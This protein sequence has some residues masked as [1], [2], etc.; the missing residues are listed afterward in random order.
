MSVRD[1]ELKN[2]CTFKRNHHS[3]S[4]VKSKE[5]R[6][7]ISVISSTLLETAASV[8]VAATVVG[9]TAT[10][11]VRRTKAS[12]ETT[13]QMVS[14][15]SRKRPTASN[16][17]RARQTEPEPVEVNVPVG[18]DGH[19]DANNDYADDVIGVEDDRVDNDIGIEADLMEDNVGVDNDNTEPVSN[20]PEEP[21]LLI[22]FRNHVAAAVWKKKERGPLKCLNRFRKLAEWPWMSPTVQKVRWRHL[23]E[24][25]GLSV[26]IDY[27]YRHGNRVAIFAFVE[28]WHLETNTFHTLDGEMTVTL[29][30]VRT[31]LG[32]P[33][34]GMALSCPK[35]TRYE[36]AELVNATLGV[37]VNDAFAE[38]IQSRG[39]SVKL[40]WL[41]IR[42]HEVNDT[43]D[44][45]FIEY[46]ARAYLLYLLGC[47]LFTDKSGTQVLVAYLHM[48]TDIDAISSYA[49]GAA[50][51]VFLYRQLGLASRAGVKQIAG[52]LK[53]LEAWIYKHFRLGRPH[54]NLSYSD[55]QPRV[56][57]WSPRRDK[58]FTKDHLQTLR[59]Q[60][61][62]LRAN[63]IE[64]DPYRLCR[65][66]HPLHV[67]AYYTGCLK[68]FDIVELYHPN[69]V[70]RQFGRVQTIPPEP[71]SPC[72]DAAFNVGAA[73]HRL[74]RDECVLYPDMLYETIGRMLQ[75]L[76]GQSLGSGSTCTEYQVYYRKRRRMDRT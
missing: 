39:Q 74:G 57:C 38:L 29:D 53:L 51:L 76:D 54:L 12:E 49:W 1:S 14:G 33:V 65:T 3:V 75:V 44:A 42:F 6:R 70:L 71:L 7:K 55:E 35:L 32:I 62:M 34:T 31:I 8:A 30:D 73:V 18:E 59:E 26:L 72:N 58:G 28:R 45:N 66:H 9:T 48:L 22:S 10:L 56:C 15:V 20:T 11:V 68:C 21:S 2:H 63:E 23:V 24:Q 36:A 19:V 67:V 46:V 69:R 61:D 5:P 16:R 25:S 50:A 41:R 40:E 37:P 47:T 27:T 17:R 52:Y 43:D 60:L 13:V 64:W 4:Y